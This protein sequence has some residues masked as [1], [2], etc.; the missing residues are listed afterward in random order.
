MD[1]KLKGQRYCVTGGAG[2]IGSHLAEALFNMGKEVL[3]IDDMSKGSTNNLRSWWDP[4][5]CTLIKSD[6]SDSKEFKDIKKDIQSC[7][8]I[9]H[10][11]AAKSVDCLHEPIQDLLTNAKGSF[12]VFLAAAEAGRKVVHASTGTVRGGSPLTFYGVSKYAAELYLNAIRTY[13]PEFRYTIL[14]YYHVYGP[15]QWSTTGGVV[16]QFMKKLLHNKPV[17]IDGTGEQT[18]H[19][20][21]VKDIVKANL[22]VGSDAWHGGFG[23]CNVINPIAVSINGLYSHICKRFMRDKEVYDAI[24]AP[25]R[26]GDKSEFDE[27]SKTLTDCGFFFEWNLADGLKETWDHYSKTLVAGGVFDEGSNRTT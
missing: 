16:F 10:N 24:Y 11:A 20:T 9:F 8:V 19:F 14:R 17:K 27:E 7:D 4:K 2:F 12:S 21:Y 15:R 3:V 25:A 18:R 1:F 26:P 22:F 13:Y 6:L 5:M 23:P